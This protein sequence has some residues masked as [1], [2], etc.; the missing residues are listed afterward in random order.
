MSQAGSIWNLL[1]KKLLLSTELCFQMANCC[2]YKVNAI[3][4]LQFFSHAH[5]GLEGLY[6]STTSLILLLRFI[7]FMAPDGAQIQDK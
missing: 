4:L 5:R 3:Y 7:F 1:K 2:L 6:I